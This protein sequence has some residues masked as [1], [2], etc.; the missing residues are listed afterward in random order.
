MN[1]DDGEPANLFASHGG[2]GITGAVNFS[3]PPPPSFVIGEWCLS[4]LAQ[5]PELETKTGNSFLCSTTLGSVLL[6]DN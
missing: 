1:K 6:V 3:S 2:G 4:G 5:K